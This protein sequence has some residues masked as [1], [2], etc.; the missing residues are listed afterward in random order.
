MAPA[1]L[2]AENAEWKAR[3]TERG[4]AT[5]ETRDE[6]SE[7]ALVTLAAVLEVSVTRP[8]QRPADAR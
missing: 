6:G 5:V 1:G 3:E 8:P 7:R 4:A 2:L